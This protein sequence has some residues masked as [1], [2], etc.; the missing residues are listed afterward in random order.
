[1][2]QSQ[3]SALNNPAVTPSVVYETRRDAAENERPDALQVP[4]QDEEHNESRNSDP[5]LFMVPG[6]PRMVENEDAPQLQLRNA[7]S[8]RA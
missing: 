7:R 4:G 1:M 2:S 3:Q 6:A 5:G 8:S